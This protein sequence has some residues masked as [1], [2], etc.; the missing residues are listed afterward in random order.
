MKL[1]KQ[2]LVKF[3]KIFKFIKNFFEKRSLTF[4]SGICIISLFPV[5]LLKSRY[6]QII[7]L[8][9]IKFYII[10]CFGLDTHYE[11]YKHIHTYFMVRS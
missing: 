3:F 5:H 2:I 11:Y 8:I 6:L 1:R 10:I 7:P 4:N 9:V